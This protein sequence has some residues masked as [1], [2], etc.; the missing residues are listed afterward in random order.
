MIALEFN[1]AVLRGPAR[2]HRVLQLARERSQLRGRFEPFHARHGLPIPAGVKRNAEDRLLRGQV[3]AHAHFFREAASVANLTGQWIRPLSA[4]LLLVPVAVV[5]RGPMHLTRLMTG[6]VYL[7][8]HNVLTR[9]PRASRPMA[10]EDRPLALYPAYFDLGRTRADGRRVPKKLA[11]DGPNVE[12]IERA[13]RALGLEPT[14]EPSAAYSRTHW[15]RE[16][17]VLVRAEY[18]KTSVLRKVAEKMKAARTG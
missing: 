17:R 12:E 18:Y 9:I 7:G 4:S 14:V 13:A 5:P 6:R 15:R 10:K 1:P 8:L 3:L 11:V 16:G 2:R